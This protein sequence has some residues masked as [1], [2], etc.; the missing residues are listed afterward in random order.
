[1]YSMLTLNFMKGMAYMHSLYISWFEAKT[2]SYMGNGV[3]FKWC[4]RSGFSQYL[5]RGILTTSKHTFF[6]CLCAEG[7][8]F[9]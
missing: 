3:T 9:S 6:Q 4:V 1:M 5:A 2:S 8:K 7:L